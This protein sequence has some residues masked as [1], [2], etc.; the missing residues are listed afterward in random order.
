MRFG[1]GIRKGF[2]YSLVFASKWEKGDHILYD[3]RGLAITRRW[4][5]K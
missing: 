1:L 3:F 2:H 4:V 5:G